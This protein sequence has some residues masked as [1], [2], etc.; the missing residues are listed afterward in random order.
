VGPLNIPLALPSNKIT[1][2]RA[3]RGTAMP[4]NGKRNYWNLAPSLFLFFWL[5]IVVWWVG[6]SSF[7]LPD[8]SPDQRAANEAAKPLSS[9][10]TK[11]LCRLAAVCKKYTATRLECATAGNLKTCLQ[12]KMGRD[13]DFTS[14]CSDN[15]D[16]TLSFQPPHMPGA[17]QCF[18]I[19]AFGNWN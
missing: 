15:G 6:S 19:S 1:Y 7:L 2:L 13:Y 4:A 12:I 10:E 9:A 5:G 16:G 14:G 8:P 17:I 18:L 3:K 11:Q